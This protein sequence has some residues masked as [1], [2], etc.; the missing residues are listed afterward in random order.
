MRDTLYNLLPDFITGRK[1]VNLTVDAVVYDTNVLVAINDGYGRCVI[2]DIFDTDANA[3]KKNPFLILYG[4]RENQLIKRPDD[5]SNTWASEPTG[6]FRFTNYMDSKP[7]IVKSLDPINVR[8]QKIEQDLYSI[9]VLEKK[10]LVETEI[11]IDGTSYPVTLLKKDEFKRCL[12]YKSLNYLDLE[13]FS[14]NKP[15][16]GSPTLYW[17]DADGSSWKNAEEIL[18]KEEDL[19]KI[20]LGVNLIAE[21]KKFGEFLSGYTHQYKNPD[22]QSRAIDS[23]IEFAQEGNIGTFFL[24]TQNFEKLI[25]SKKNPDGTTE[26]YNPLELLQKYNS[27]KEDGKKIIIGGGTDVSYLWYP[28]DSSLSVKDGEVY[29]GDGS[30]WRVLEKEDYPLIYRLAPENIGAAKLASQIKQQLI[31]KC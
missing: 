13:H 15:L 5:K 19:P 6:M 17:L 7:D 26:S 29:E 16:V 2:A 11:K 4:L 23:A 27:Q 1:P 22:Y 20:E 8:E 21:E 18:P 14:L 30:S 9:C 25:F 3:N 28:K 24:V 31:E 12:I 10:Y